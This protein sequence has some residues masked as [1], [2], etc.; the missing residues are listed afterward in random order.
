MS[1]KRRSE[2]KPSPSATAVQPPRWFL[3]AAWAAVCGAIALLLVVHLSA[4]RGAA[5]ELGLPL[6]DGWIHAQFARN[7]A[8]GLGFSFN[9]GE[10]TSTT[11][12]PLWTLLLAL[13]YRITGE[14]L[15]TGI[16][17][18]Y[19]LAVVLCALV[20]RLSLALH[21]SRWIA[22]C[23]AG[24]VAVTVPL[25]WWALS[26]MEPVLYATLALL[27]I[28]LHLRTRLKPGLRAAP[29][30]VVFALAGLARPECFLLFPLAVLDRLIMAVRGEDR[31]TALRE[32]AAHLAIHVPLFI[33]VACPL[34]LYNY[35]VTGYPLPTSFYSKLQ[36][37]GLSG[38]L[39]SDRVSFGAALMV[40]PMRELGEVLLVWAGD[41]VV[42]APA[43]LVGLIWLVWRGLRREGGVPR[44]LLIPLVLI[45]Q[46]IIWAIA[47]GYRPPD[48]QSQRYLAN[49]NPLFILAG[50][51][52]GW[53]LTER[54]AA[55]HRPAVRG[56][57][58]AAALAAS[59]AA[60]PA[61]VRTYALNVKN[62]TEMQVRIGRWLE[63]NVPGSA[64][65]AVNDIGAIGFISGCRVLDLQGLVTPEVLER[66][67]ME[68]KLDRTAP[69]ALF[70]FIV[71]NRPDYLVIFPQ[72]YP[73]LHARSDLFQPVFSVELEDNITCGAPVMI[74][75]RTIW[76]GQPTEERD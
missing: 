56:A 30:T 10:R 59:L 64:L 54:I 19:L 20:Y 17:I 37:M 9:P 40:A 46:P 21:P 55:L 15:F 49:L 47:A 12:G 71:A 58:V 57:L 32:W 76:A 23:A 3:I 39:A 69:R 63:K 5:G 52:G 28:L 41:N 60:Q 4:A 75:Y 38:A 36:W 67:S 24:L 33:L 45:A 48:Y 35:L 11:T 51:L 43:F 50:V 73:E 74:V 13:G 27:G 65:L 72:W 14:H 26:G 16:V 6:D 42:L 29:A 66:R 31:T 53:W 2:R 25:P 70:D 18:N 7:L 1:R 44:S 34:F 68:R 61:A 62:T 22:I 8:R